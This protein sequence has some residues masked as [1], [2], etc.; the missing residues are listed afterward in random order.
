MLATDI[1]HS[2]SAILGGVLLQCGA[3]LIS[4]VML[5]SSVFS[6]T[7]AWLGIVMHG[8]DLAHI[9]C[10]LILARRR[11]CSAFNRRT[12]LSGLVYFG[13]P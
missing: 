10:G 8:L 2:T 6:K 3:V 4:V 7:T 11:L 1:W 12:A 13:R 5:R 9:L